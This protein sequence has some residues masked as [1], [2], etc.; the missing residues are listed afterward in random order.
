M[1]RSSSPDTGCTALVQI[2]AV[3]IV[4]RCFPF[5]LIRRTCGKRAVVMTL[6]TDRSVPVPLPRP[7]VPRMWQALSLH[8]F[9]VFFVTFVT[10]VAEKEAGAYPSTLQPSSTIQLHLRKTLSVNSEPAK[11]SH[12][13]CLR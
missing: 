13:R 10:A 1:R 12:K 5:D 8:Q 3:L 4:L 9:K 6:T 2:L 7:P 11:V